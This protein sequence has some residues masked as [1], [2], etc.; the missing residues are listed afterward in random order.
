[1]ELFGILLA[2]IFFVLMLFYGFAFPVWMII[3][4]GISERST[5]AKAVWILV[6]LLTWTFGAVLYGV[7]AAKQVFVKVLS[8][9][10][11]LG[12]FAIGGAVLVAMQLASP[13]LKM[14]PEAIAAQIDQLKRPGIADGEIDGLKAKVRTLFEE[15]PLSFST[16]TEKPERFQVNAFLMQKL[17]TVANDGEL[18][19]EEFDEW[20]KLYEMRKVLDPEKLG[21]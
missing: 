21:E 5:T 2:I 18:S 14:A 15:T 16:L 8:A 19:R 11:A 17:S 10:G 12:V 9:I 3:D 1:M 4:V 13:Y 6:M 20:V 7:F